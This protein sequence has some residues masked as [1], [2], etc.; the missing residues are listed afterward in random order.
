MLKKLLVAAG[1]LSLA[2]G[3]LGVFIPL[4]PT[5]PF[6]L[7]SAACYARGSERF[8]RW[9]T[10]HRHLGRYIS[11]YR[12]GRGIPL[13]TKVSAIV[14]L[15]S[16]IVYAVVAITDGVV[17]EALLLIIAGGVTTHLLS[18]P[19]RRPGRPQRECGHT[20]DA[21]GSSAIASDTD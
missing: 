18:L 3:I 14:L 8:Y 2:L 4:L 12:E 11:D 21:D 16:S 19:T 5:T 13:G 17:V 9:L 15:W 7:L 1:T 20:A 6:L 10:G